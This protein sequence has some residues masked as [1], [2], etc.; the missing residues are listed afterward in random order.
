ML[1]ACF[2]VKR[3][4]RIT[5]SVLT[6]E[7]LR[8]LDTL[9]VR[10]LRLHLDL[11]RVVAPTAGGLGGL[12]RLDHRL[13]RQGGQLVI[14]NVRPSAYKVFLLTGLANALSVKPRRRQAGTPPR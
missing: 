3:V 6:E 9:D 4:V 2:S 14:G 5:D 1:S 10:G 13:R 7:S 8:R 11:A 12:V